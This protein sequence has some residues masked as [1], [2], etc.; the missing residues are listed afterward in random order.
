MVS[1]I[2]F[3]ARELGCMDKITFT[4]LKSDPSFCD[5][6]LI[7]NSGMLRPIDASFLRHVGNQTA[8]SYMFENWEVRPGD[9][10]LEYCKEKQI[11]VYFSEENDPRFPVFHFCGDL[12][13]KLCRESGV[14]PGSS[15][16]TVLSSDK[17]GPVV[18][19]ALRKQGASVTL[20]DNSEY[21]KIRGRHF[22]AVVVA[23]FCLANTII[24]GDIPLDWIDNPD[25]VIIQLAGVNNIELIRD[26]NMRPYPD[27]QLPPHKMSRTLSYLG[28]RPVIILHA[29][30]LKV[31]QSV[32]EARRMGLVGAEMDAYVM[33]HSPAQLNINMNRCYSVKG[34]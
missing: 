3:L 34:D 33:E 4:N 23:E 10:D 22:H 29:I 32:V 12:A 20:L 1:R 15:T 25:A 14:Y 17:F 6:D 13:N 2:E 16:I 21:H 31:G 7:T 26:R 28:P 9:V 30:G 24:G 18:A 11:P 19:G 8:I 5:A 27:E